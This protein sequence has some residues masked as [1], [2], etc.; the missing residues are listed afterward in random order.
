MIMIRVEICPDCGGYK[1]VAEPKEIELR[2]T[3]GDSSS[4]CTCCICNPKDE[5][6]E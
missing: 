1:I 5:K 6:E 3:S 4:P 2:G